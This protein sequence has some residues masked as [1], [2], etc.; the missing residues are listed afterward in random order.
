MK[1]FLIALL[2]LALPFVFYLKNP[3]GREAPIEFPGHPVS[4]SLPDINERVGIVT[5]GESL[6]DIF[7][8]YELNLQSLSRL[9]T[10]ARG[11]YNLYRLTPKHSYII[12]TVKYEG[13]DKEKISCFK[14]SIDDFSYLKIID[15]SD[16]Y[17]AE[18]VALTF[19][20]RPSYISG[21]IKENFINSI[22]SSRERLK[23]AFNFTD[24]FESEIDFLTELR[25]GD[26]Y[27]L[28]VEEFWLE[29]IFKGYGDIL[30]A[31]FINNA[32]RYE[33]YRFEVDGIPDYYDSKGNSIKKA[34]IR[35]PLRF[36]HI[37]SNF[38]YKRK[39]PILKI[40]RPHLGVDYA[41]PSG[42]PVSAAGNGTVIFAGWKGQYGK[43]VV[44][45]H[46]N[47]YK[48]YYGHLSKINRAIKK[49]KKVSQGEIIAYVGTTGLSTGPHLDYRIKRDEKFV[50]PLMMNLPKERHV[51]SKLLPFFKNHVASLEGV[52]QKK[53]EEERRILVKKKG[54]L[55]I[56]S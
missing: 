24:I 17:R 48:T 3:L 34:L 15:K 27:S 56:E 19:D 7:K 9:T 52:L 10:A 37:S 14:Y 54:T 38:S 11:V 20:R 40:Y 53:S 50:N 22:G 18:R 30:T 4:L 51:P 42:T 1:K 8:K 44:I 26:S 28:L 29:G 5:N 13:S 31:K 45:N 35:A 46:P 49:G 41:A 32:R 6:F 25:E 12:T 55:T 21:T 39:H 23:L 47:G 33:V 2:L 36:R 43:T 16:E